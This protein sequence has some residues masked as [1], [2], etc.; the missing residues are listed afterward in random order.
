MR[1][2]RDENEKFRGIRGTVREPNIALFGVSEGNE[3]ENGIAL[4]SEHTV[5]ENLLKLNKHNKSTN[6]IVQRIPSRITY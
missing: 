6:L 1:G 5:A 4:I 2:Q 3:K